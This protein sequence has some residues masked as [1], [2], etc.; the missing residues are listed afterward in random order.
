MARCQ[1]R[2]DEWSMAG[3]AVRVR[4]EGMECPDWTHGGAVVTVPAAEHL[5]RY[6]MAARGSLPKLLC[7]D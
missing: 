7:L 1:T 4:G 2:V 5:L 6:S 3:L